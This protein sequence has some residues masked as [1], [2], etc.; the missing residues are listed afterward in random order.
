M[1]RDVDG[2]EG[3]EGR[4]GREGPEER[5]DGDKEIGRE[6]G[7]EKIGKETERKERVQM[8]EVGEGR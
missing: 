6:G 7:G 4:E 5:G 3:Q 1:G 8:G 2:E